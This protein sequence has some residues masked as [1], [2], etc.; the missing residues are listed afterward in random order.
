[1]HHRQEGGQREIEQPFVP[2]DTS[3]PLSETW[4]LY[5]MIQSSLTWYS[6]CTGGVIDDVEGGHSVSDRVHENKSEESQGGAPRQGSRNRPQNRARTDD[7]DDIQ[8]V[9][10]HFRGVDEEATSIEDDGTVADEHKTTCNSSKQV[11]V[12]RDSEP[13]FVN[14]VSRAII[15]V[16]ATLPS[17]IPTKVTNDV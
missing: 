7:A 12:G 6:V 4:Y 11:E 8:T 9:I 5:D 2:L 15:A 3:Y 17:A 10:E 16:G 1:M 14:V 13:R